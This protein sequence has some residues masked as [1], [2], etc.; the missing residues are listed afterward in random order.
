[1]LFN[2]LEFFIFFPVVFVLYWFLFNKN[3]KVQNIFLLVCSYFFYGW[4]DWRFL[5]LLLFSTLIDYGFGLLIYNN[6]GKKQSLYLWLSVANNLVFLG[7]F[8]Y[9]NFFA[10]STASLLHHMGVTIHPYLLNI[11]LPI[12]ISFYTFHGMSYVFD[13]YRQ[14]TTPTK[15]F[16]DYAVFVC[17]FPLLVAGPIE[18]A[19][20][21]L[22]QVQVKR[23]F[24]LGQAISG[25]RLILWGFFKKTVI[26]DSSAPLVNTIF[27]SHHTMSGFALLTGAVFFAF[28]IYGDFSGY[29][30]IAI[31]TAKLLGF[32]LI[33]NFNFPYYCKSVSD[34]WR[35]W[36]ISLYS[37]FMDYL[38]TPLSTWLRDWGKTAIYFSMIVTFMLSGLWH[39]AAWKFILFGLLQGLAI[40]YEIYTQKGRKKLAK[41]MHPLLFNFFARGMTLTFL[42]LTF[43]LFRASTAR[44]AG[45]YIREMFTNPFYKRSD[46]GLLIQYS[47][48]PFI[49]ILLYVIEWI[50]KDANN[51]APFFGKIQHAFTRYSF[52]LLIFVLIIVLGTFEKTAFIYFQF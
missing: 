42:L 36:H 50:N 13:I 14:K 25:L 17:F 51:I 29:S 41:K 22:P 31:G 45:Q 52:Y 43:I 18:R 12:G 16:V 1:M 2:S 48:L 9:Y 27:E 3:L 33:I 8:K 30:D 11:A 40:S 32:E 35:R 37:W 23:F 46:N 28:Q 20:H 26:A 19:T 7:F 44:V 34:F 15:N 6:K 4:W 39:G 38:F 49:F 10:E 47:F 24:N 21:L 5:F